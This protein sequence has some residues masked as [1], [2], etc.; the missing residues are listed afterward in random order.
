MPLL[1]RTRMTAIEPPT[2]A[3]TVQGKARVRVRGQVCGYVQCA[4]ERRWAWGSFDET[5]Q[6]ARSQRV[7][8]VR[9]I[10]LGGAASQTLRFITGIDLRLVAPPALRGCVRWSRPH[11]PAMAPLSAHTIRALSGTEST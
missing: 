6:L 11:V 9:A 5:F 10:G 2:L 8:T 4:G 7:S 3:L 1:V